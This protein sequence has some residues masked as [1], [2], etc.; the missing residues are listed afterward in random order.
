MIA[1]HRLSGFYTVIRLLPC[2][3][4]CGAVFIF[5]GCV[6][7][8]S[9][10]TSSA[11]TGSTVKE[12][13]YGVSIAVPPGWAIDESSPSAETA[14]ASLDARAAKGE[15]IVLFSMNRPSSNPEGRDALVALFLVDS[16]RV[17]QPEEA[18]AT[19]MPDDLE[20]YGEAI[21]ARDKEAAR[22]NKTQSNLL[23]WTVSK[24]QIDGNLTLIHKGTAKGP[25]GILD[26]YDI[27]VYLPNG[28]G[29]ALKSVS[30]PGVPG[31]SELMSALV[32]SLHIRK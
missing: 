2:L 11:L 3:L 32:A 18:T 26:L 4:L 31:T 7:K 10:P 5:A 1:P 15:R 25:N 30:D 24:G 19:L 20:R 6:P 16:T 28:K 22:L 27:N 14:K 17:F 23:T 13:A 29:L 8:P 12:L 21:L 9:G